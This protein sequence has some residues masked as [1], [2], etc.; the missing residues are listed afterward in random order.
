MVSRP[1]TAA[2]RL[3]IINLPY[4]VIGDA[5][6][7]NLNMFG[8]KGLVTFAMLHRLEY[9]EN[10]SIKVIILLRVSIF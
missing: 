2:R 9:V 7:L 8:H 3:L 4:E 6:L 5:P 10:L 1:K